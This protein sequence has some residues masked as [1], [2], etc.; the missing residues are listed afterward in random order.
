MSKSGDVAAT[1]EGIETLVEW[2]GNPR[3]SQPVSEVAESIRR[4]GFGAPVIARASDRVLIAGHTRLKA[5]RE[6][7][8]THVPVRF[9]DISEEEAHS[10][11]T[12][13]VSSPS[14]TTKHCG[15]CSQT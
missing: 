3:Q 4:F 12:S 8:H 7:G 6:L 2:E 10:L 11:T 15:R 1:W 5:A 14:G 13:S 9:L